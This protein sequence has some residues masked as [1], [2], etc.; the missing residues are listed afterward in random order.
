MLRRRNKAQSTV[1]YTV[2]IIVIMAALLSIQI[3]FKRGVQGRWKANADSMGDQY[4]PRIAETNI[5]FTLVTQ[6]N[7]YIDAEQVTGGVHT[8]RRDE[9]EATERKQG[10]MTVSY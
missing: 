8:M 5:L 10:T 3:Y 6:T 2:F 1:E 4:D 7:T 9:A